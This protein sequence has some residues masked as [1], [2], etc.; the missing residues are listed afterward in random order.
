MPI[1]R[2]GGFL[3]DDFWDM[4]MR[5][6]KQQGSLELWMRQNIAWGVFGILV[7]LRIALSSR[8]PSYIL[9]GTPHDDG[10][11]VGRAVSIINGDWLGGYDQYTL[12]KGA[13]SPLLMAF[14]ALFG[15]TYSGLNT[16]IYC[17]A[18]FVFVASV[19]PVIKNHWFLLL[20]F[21]ILLFNPLTYAMETGQRIYRNGIG[22]WEI[23]LAFGGLIAVLFRR[24]ADWKV[25]LKWGLVSGFA[26]GAFMQTRE[27]GAWIYPF[28]IG[29]IASTVL[30]YLVEQRSGKKK[31]LVFFVPVFVAVVLNLAMA[32]VNY[33]TYG[34]LV[35]NDR[36]GGNFSRV[37]G[38]LYAISPDPEEDALYKS[39]EYKGKYYNIYVST[40][41]KAFVASPTLNSA[42]KSIREAI[43][44]W[45]N[46]EDIKNG[47]LSTDHMLFALRDGVKGAGYYKSLPETEAFYEKV[48]EE[49]KAAFDKGLLVKQGFPVSPLMKRLQR[50]DVGKALSLMP[51]AAKDVVTFAGVSAVDFPPVGPPEGIREFV[52]MAGGEYNAERGRLIGGGWAFAKN[53]KVV[54]SAGL[55]DKQGRLVA[56]LPFSAGDD[57]FAHMNSIGFK[58]QNA[59]RSRFA[60]DV[61]GFDLN[62]GVVLKFVDPN[63]EI[64]REIPLDGSA[65]NGDND[66]F[67]YHFEQLSETG[68]NS[69]HSR[70][71]K[72]A[73]RVS[74]AYQKVALVL[75][76]LACFAYLCATCMLITEVAMRKVLKTLPVWLVL[77]GT[78]LTFI[79]FL[80]GMCLITAT[81]FNALH[82]LYTAPAYILSLIFCTGAFFW[83]VQN[84][85]EIGKRGIL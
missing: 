61:E 58:Y 18:C 51:K 79:L 80:F 82:Y 65:L 84:I 66:S 64:F 69:V 47:Q 9:A 26:L 12:I 44:M 23:L 43:Q 63:G 24:H 67:R 73:N 41:E 49:L 75:F 2:C 36:N 30:L 14:T 22:Q 55:Y 27:D 20:M 35:L 45:A 37:A 60:F 78:L 32:F 33:K 13:F 59:K 77:T 62:S 85:T 34:A 31:I 15:V 68:K 29:V 5:E 50:G 6:L 74:S 7:I 57:V 3:I 81:S 76:W 38:D 1:G 42:S 4:Q 70:F 72:R 25:L 28:V 39:E 52:F 40:M 71:V 16:A 83:G 17:L 53:D 54:L 48:H 56:N 11:V 10:W 46:W 8:L 21:A 19:R